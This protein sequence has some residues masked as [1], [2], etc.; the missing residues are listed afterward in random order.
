MG[1][2]EVTYE[3]LRGYVFYIPE[4][5]VEAIKNANTKNGEPHHERSYCAYCDRWYAAL[6]D[7]YFFYSF[8]SSES[9]NNNWVA[10]PRCKRCFKI[11]VD[12]P[13]YLKRPCPKWLQVLI[14][15]VSLILLWVS[16]E[17][18]VRAENPD[19]ATA[20]WLLCFCALPLGFIVVYFSVRD[21]KRKLYE[22]ISKLH[23]IG[24][25]VIPYYVYKD[26][27]LPYYSELPRKYRKNGGFNHFATSV[28][29]TSTKFD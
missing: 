5:I 9:T 1:K 20:I 29:K 2:N 14:W 17:L 6:Y 21:R 28:Y 22:R 11:M 18:V 25:S 24:N 26:K 4:D 23:A 7:R 10:I 8:V 19:A 13:S 27:D 15:I 16:W 12:K 3:D